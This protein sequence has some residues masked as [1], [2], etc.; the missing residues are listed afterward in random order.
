M[1]T[2]TL[3]AI[4]QKVRR[5]TRSPSTAQLT[6]ADLDQYINTF[7]L[8]D[9]PEHLR[10][11]ILHEKFSFVCNAYQDLYMTDGS[12]AAPNPL[13][14]FQQNYLTINKPVYIAGYLAF[15]TQSQE[16]FYNIYPNINF[17]VQV[18]AGTGVQTTFTGT[19]QSATTNNP[20]NPL[21]A[22]N[23]LFGS[24]DS[25]GNSLALVDTPVVDAITGLPTINGNLYAPGSI[26][27][28][29][30]TA[31]NPNNTINYVTGIFTCTFT[32]APGDTIPV[33]VQM[34]QYQPSRPLAMLYYQNQITLRPIPDQPYSI[35]FEVFAR[36]T[37]LLSEGQSPQLEEWWQYIAYGAAK[38][39]FE[40][41]MDMESVQAI[42][43]EYRKQE[44]LCNRRSLVQYQNQRTATI[45]TEIYG[46][47]TWGFGHGGN[48]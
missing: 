46:G 29:P 15:F 39:I 41:R 31:I 33:N 26:P 1:A 9:F 6:E 45:Y 43:P 21:I 17:L 35:N 25:L 3:A 34:I 36:P 47:N 20:P 10:M 8:Y 28:I 16:E 12:Y 40:D 48:F 18:G 37:A 11:F 42:M 38:K 13:N 30:P 7:V 27:A 2:S 32:A 24:I 14:N 44:N 19:V 4:E 5:L 22:N 23:V